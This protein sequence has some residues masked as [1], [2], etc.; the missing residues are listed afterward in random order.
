VGGE[1]NKACLE[2][3][4]ECV[5]PEA[6]HLQLFAKMMTVHAFLRKKKKLNILA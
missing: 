1:D 6:R 4:V 5:C 2:E 3:F